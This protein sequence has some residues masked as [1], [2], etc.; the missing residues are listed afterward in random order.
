MF[1]KNEISLEKEKFDLA[2]LAKEVMDSMKLQFEKQNAT[3]SLEISGENFTI[4]ADKL[5][6][7]SVIY[8]LLDN[9]LKYGKTIHKS[10]F[11]F[12]TVLNI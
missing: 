1:E 2:G 4:E 11:P 5:H 8:N 3:A 10:P 6:M 9:A 12:L 7:A